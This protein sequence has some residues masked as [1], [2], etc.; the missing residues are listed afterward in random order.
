MI[1]VVKEAIDSFS[2]WDLKMQKPAMNHSIVTHQ[3]KIKLD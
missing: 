1:L 2:F 3:T